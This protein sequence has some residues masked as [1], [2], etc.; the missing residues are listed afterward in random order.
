LVPSTCLPS[1][2]HL[3][4]KTYKCA[5]L[6]AQDIKLFQ[7]AFY[8]SANKVAE[9]NFI[10]KY[11]TQGP[12]KRRRPRN[13]LN[14]AKKEIYTKYFVPTFESRSGVVLLQVCQKAFV[15]ILG[16]SKARVQR[17]STLQLRTGE[18]PRERRGGDTRSRNF[19]DKRNAVRDFLEN[20]FPGE[21]KRGLLSDQSIRKLWQSYNLQCDPS[22]GVT[23]GQLRLKNSI[24]NE[25]ST[26]VKRKK[27][28]T[29]SGKER[30]PKIKKTKY[31]PKLKPNQ[32]AR[33][34]TCKICFEEFASRKNLFDHRKSV[35][36]D[37][38]ETIKD[39]EAEKLTY[40]NEY[41]FYTCNNCS[42]EFQ[43]K[44]EA[45]K[46]YE[47]HE[48][49]YDCEVCSKTVAGALNFSSHLQQHREDKN[50]PCPLCPHM[51]SRKSAMLIHIVRF[52]YRKYDFQC[53]SCGKCFN[54]ALSFKEHENFHLGVKPFICIVCNKDFIY[55]RYLIAHQI[56]N[57]RV[58]VLDK[59]SKTQCHILYPV[60]STH[61]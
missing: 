12:P 22:L 27:S 15:H 36:E 49:K 56:R 41:D 31:V 60:E 47:T 13:P 19:V 59:D 9:D 21:Q 28:N 44:E 43:T 35:H 34:W 14:T 16:I 51:T 40:D 32:R 61:K 2:N 25:K 6:S 29:S 10:V 48:E 55:S 20:A 23:Y 57:H 4:T 30:K 46:H 1:C 7:I 58:R 50:F 39:E 42:A 53:Q 3:S 26:K 38:E 8:N 17:L 33:S 37:T 24:V 5:E 54:D 11:I 45:E 52:H 18:A